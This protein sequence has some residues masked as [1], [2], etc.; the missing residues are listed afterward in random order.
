[1]VAEIV[2]RIFSVDLIAV[3]KGENMNE[4]LINRIAARSTCFKDLVASLND[5]DLETKLDVQKSKSLKEHFW[6]IIG[7]R[8][9]YLKAIEAGQWQG[10]NCSLSDFTTQGIANALTDTEEKLF[11]IV[12]KM[13]SWSGEQSKLLLSLFEHETMHEGQIIRH[14]YGVGGKL[15]SSWRW[16]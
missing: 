10:F 5:G 6:C 9:S 7:A 4:E 16:A 2:V 12:S 14:I 15:P 1:M 8:Q 3:S 11:Q 13:E